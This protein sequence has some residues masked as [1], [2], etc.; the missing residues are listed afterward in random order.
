M[1]NLQIQALSYTIDKK[2]ILDT[3]N[4][5]FKAGNITA[6]A[7]ANGAGKSTL[8][9]CL[10]GIITNYE[11][12]ILYQGQNLRE[13][14]TQDKAKMIAYIPQRESPTFD[15]AVTDYIMLGR[16][17]YIKWKASNYDKTL[18]QQTMQQLKIK[19]LANNRLKLISGGEYQK[20]ALARALVQETDILLLDEPTSALDIK[21]QIEV[22]QILKTITK[23]KNVIVIIVL[24]ELNL[25]SRFSDYL[26]LLNQGQVLGA[27]ET[28]TILNK[29]NITSAFDV[30]SQFL[31]SMHGNI[32]V[33][34]L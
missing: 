4:C 33:P 14:N 9:K 13:L 21:Y 30:N 3:I 22:M 34:Y 11:G 26:L 1:K 5:N 27:G 23:E 17:P 19:H 8:L 16:K 6:I 10:L 28:S 31:N 15:S 20:V 24:H 18:V 29:K 32:V 25:V 12:T 7:G 2:Q